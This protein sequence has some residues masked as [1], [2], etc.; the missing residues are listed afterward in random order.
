MI[1]LPRRSVTRF[2]IPLIDVMTL[3]FCI[4]L[5]MPTVADPERLSQGQA[6]TLAE[7]TEEIEMLRKQLAKLPSKAEVDQLKREVE[8]LRDELRKKV[9]GR[10]DIRILEFDPKTG[11]LYHHDPNRLFNKEIAIA[12][13]ADAQK[14]I[15]E[16]REDAGDREV[17]YLFWLPRAANA[18]FPTQRQLDEYKSWFKGTA[19]GLDLPR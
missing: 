14:L 4:Y 18:L 17:Y 7:A 12:S 1:E 3:L 10:K 16:N 8:D 5:L 13:A 11:K 9:T 15:K 19:Y 6:A 2:F